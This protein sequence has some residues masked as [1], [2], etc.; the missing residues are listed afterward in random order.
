MSELERF[1][2][3]QIN[4]YETALKEIKNGKKASCWMW[5][6]FPQII[7]LGMTSTAQYYG[8]KNIEEAIEYLNNEILGTRLVEISQ[9]LLELDD[10]TNINEVMGYPDNLKLK[11]S[12][13]LFKKA[14]EESGNKYDDIFQKVLD[15]YYNG[16][17]DQ[18]TLDILSSQNKD[19]IRENNN[20]ERITEENENE[21]EKEETIE[22]SKAELEESKNENIIENVKLNEY[23]DEN[24]ET[25]KENNELETNESEINEVHRGCYEYL[26]S[27]C[28][29]I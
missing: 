21:K 26:K 7:G 10:D 12:M 3:A 22:N 1:L 13:T 4:D 15:K 2:K 11:S 9:A 18:K 24:N 19:K 23:K 27:S 29:I 17:E 8:I 20:N 25:K 5:Y 14:S 6:I 28:E 16:Q